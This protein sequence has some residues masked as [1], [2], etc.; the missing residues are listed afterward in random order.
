MKTSYFG[1]ANSNAFK[2]SGLRFVCI[3]RSCRYFNGERYPDLF[4]TWEMIKMSDPI[5]Y[6]EM[7]REQ[8]LSKLDPIKVYED[9][10]DAV[11]LCHEKWDDIVDGKTFCHRRIVA[12]W[13]EE[14]LWVRGIDVTIDELVDEKAELKKML[15]RGGRK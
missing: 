7:Y 1:R 3:A 11:L 9:L 15:K 12:Q 6:E 5:K 2:N 14:E 8:V 4:P 13:L 10:K